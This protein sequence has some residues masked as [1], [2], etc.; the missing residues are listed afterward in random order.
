MAA[1]V[2]GVK[3]KGDG[4]MRMTLSSGR[5]P[6]L[7]RQ[8]QF[9][10]YTNTLFHPSTADTGLWTFMRSLLLLAGLLKPFLFRFSVQLQSDGHRALFSIRIRHGV[11]PKLYNTGSEGGNQATASLTEQFSFCQLTASSTSAEFNVS[12]LVT[13][14]TKTFLRYD[15]LQDLVNSIRRYYPTVTIVIADDS[16]NPKA[17]SGPNIEHYIMPFGKVRTLIVEFLPTVLN[18]MCHV[19]LCVRVG[20]QGETWPSPR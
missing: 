20:L 17:V 9:V 11:T 2:D 15:K 3:V 18:L 19:G 12:A 7:N 16:E 13:V 6:N 10:T 14:A 5:L 8:L 1:E 4:E